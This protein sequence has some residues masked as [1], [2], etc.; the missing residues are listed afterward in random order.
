MTAGISRMKAKE[1]TGKK[2]GDLGLSAETVV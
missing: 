1:E 2:M